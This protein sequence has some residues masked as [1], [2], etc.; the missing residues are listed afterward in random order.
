SHSGTA[1]P[2]GRPV[3]PPRQIPAVTPPPDADCSSATTLPRPPAAAIRTLPAAADAAPVRHREWPDSVPRSTSGA[4]G[5]TLRSPNCR[6]GPYPRYEDQNPAPLPHVATTDRRDHSAWDS[7]PRHTPC[8][9]PA[10]HHPHRCCVH[11]TPD[12]AGHRHEWIRLRHRSGTRPPV[13]RIPL[14]PHTTG[15]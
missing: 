7:R 6:L 2:S 1:I 11:R 14:P 12:N 5:R 13:N 10:A 3:R 9:D 4:A 15:C 8:P